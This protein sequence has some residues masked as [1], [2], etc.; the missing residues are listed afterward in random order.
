MLKK[1]TLTLLMLIAAVVFFKS[2]CCVV[3]IWRLASL[4]DGLQTHIIFVLRVHL[5]VHILNVVLAGAKLK[6]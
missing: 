6:L 2:E 4:Q 1:L 3:S 5:N